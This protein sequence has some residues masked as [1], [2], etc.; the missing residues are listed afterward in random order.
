MN[1]KSIIVG[2]VFPVILAGCAANRK[3]SDP[4]DYIDFVD[5]TIGTGGHGHVFV[6]ANV[7]FGFVQL[8]PTSIPQTWDWTSGYHVSD[9][10]VIGFPHTHLSGTGIGDLHDVTLMPV[11]GQVIYA[12]G[13]EDK[14]KSGLWSYAER[15]KQVVKPGYFSTHLTRYDIGV[16]LTATKRVGFH[17]Y[18]FPASA[19]AAVVFDLENGGCW[20]KP[21]DVYLSRLNDSTVVGYRHSTGWAED[22]RI[23]F[24]VSFSRPF[25]SVDVIADGKTVADSSKGKIVYGRVG[26]D[27]NREK[28]VYVKVALSPTSIENAMLNMQEELPGWDF[29][30]TVASAQR[31]WNDELSKIA[32]ETDNDTIRT[33]FYTALYHTMI[34]PSEF[35]DVNRDYFGADRNMHKDADFTNYTTFS[36]W[37][38]YRSY[39]PL[40]TLIHPEKVSDVVQSMLMIYKHTGKLPVWHLMGNET[41]TMVG[42]PGISIVGD[43]V[44]KGYVKDEQLAFEAM[45]N[46]A[47]LDERGMDLRKKYGYIPYDKSLESVAMDMEYAIA[48]WSVAQVA[49]KLGKD[50]DYKYFIA[51]SQSYKNFFDPSTGFMRGRGSKGEF[52]SPF[53][54][55]HSSHRED[56]YCE[57]NAWQYTFLVP[58]DL[59][60][61]I[62][63]FGSKE[64]FLNKL[65][66]LFVAESKLE[67]KDTSPD[68]SG[69]IGQYAHG[70][71]PSHHIIYFYS[72]LGQSGKS[73]DLLRKV[74]T[75]LYRNEADGLSGN[76]DVGAMSSWYILSSM[77]IYQVEP[78]GGRFV[79][80]SP[81]VNKATLKLQN[82]KT[83]TMTAKN[84]S[85]ANKYVQSVTLNGKPYDK[86]HIDFKDMINGG[87]LEFT[88]GNKPSS[89][90]SIK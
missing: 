62:E 68:I 35:C 76:E 49:K 11:V 23:F 43:A 18:T 85:A 37:D 54:P 59:D 7:P 14:P 70:N 28:E 22:Q 9:S 67:G 25:N 77:G 65:D 60:G 66:S 84:N 41:N 6:G 78:A 58:H 44:M 86:C 75:T 53:N 64:K 5:Q 12:R 69:L 79:F 52:H 39:H 32:I 83:F 45:K 72:M 31:T 20:D 13:T 55:Y 81:I 27:T 74:M 50:D 29:K 56:D 3:L 63:T 48:D 8:G 40:M 19:E 80:G 30:G 71:E 42:N 46:S 26:F 33:N 24:A 89:I 17:K 34:A 82:G 87:E 36:G 61:L 73:A 21:T 47:M 2:I 1:F 4:K 57:G 51:R 15:S 90:W 38:T 10:T 88:M 16:E